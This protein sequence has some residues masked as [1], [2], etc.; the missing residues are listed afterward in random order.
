MDKDYYKILGVYE[1]DSTDKIKATYRMLARRLHPDVAGNSPDVIKK[2]KEINEAYDILSDKYKRAEYDKARL[3]YN[4]AK[5]GSSGSKNKSCRNSNNDKQKHSTEPDNKGFNFKWD[6]FVK[7]YNKSQNKKEN[8]LPLKGED[9]YAEVE[10]TIFESIQGVNKIIN[11]LQTTICPKCSG[12]KF[13]NGSVC[14]HCDGKGEFSIHRKF[15]VKIPSGIKNGAKIR[16][17]G[18]G[19]TGINGGINGD[20]YITVKIKDNISYKTEGLNIIKNVFVSPHEAILGSYIE[21]KLNDA[22]YSVKIPPFT[23]N[24]QKIRLSDCG[25]MQNDKIGDMILVVEIKIPKTL[26][27]EEIALYKQLADISSSNIRDN[28]Y[29]R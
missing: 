3:F 19:G 24:G 29:D 17:S 22:I 5:N 15:N 27:K 14:P 20:L 6:E 28:Y 11:I 21:V 1:S 4:Y 12:R 7:K 25:L 16:L 26:S 9:I 2:F 18:E 8:N 10:I 23:Q 13:I